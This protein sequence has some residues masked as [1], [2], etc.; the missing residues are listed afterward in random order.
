[1]NQVGTA[2]LAN[3]SSAAMSGRLSAPVALFIFR[4]PQHL[5]AVITS[6]LDC[7]GIGDTP[8]IVFGDG[9][10][11]DRDRPEV[12]AARQLARNLLGDRATFQFREENVGLS[13]SIIEGVSAVCRDYGRVIVLEDDL[14]VAPS[15]LEYMNA[16]LER[17]ECEDRVMQVSAHMF[18]V[19]EF[20]GR[21][22]AMFL[23]I[24]T[25]W[26]WA[27]WQRAWAHFDP[28]A[29][30]WR[31]LQTDKA[32][33]V[34]FDLDGAYDYS[35]MLESQMS[36]QRDSWAIRWYW[37]VFQANGLTL[38]PPRTLV[39]NTGQ[40]GSGTHGGGVLRN[41]RISAVV[42]GG[43]PRSMP[44]D[45]RY[46]QEDYSAVRKRVCSLNGGWIGRTMDIARRM[47]RRL[48]AP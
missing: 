9:P 8:I 40:D 12:E 21:E 48:V 18:D 19:P 27:T 28:D 39:R 6:L 11:N 46:K 43:L 7:H 36:G 37:S 24:T 41:F 20:D 47:S 31:R 10:R 13:R 15:F 5:R 4:R 3:R 14:E 25:S 42:M 35:G 16:A 22:G 26:G 44:S 1:M 38:F 17:Y 45:L 29:T 34:R 30:G 23:P 2:A 32:L 33:R